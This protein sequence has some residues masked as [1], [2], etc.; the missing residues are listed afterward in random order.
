KLKEY[1]NKEGLSDILNELENI[2]EEKYSK[3]HLLKELSQKLNLSEKEKVTL[4][5]SIDIE[6]IENNTSK[7]TEIKSKKEKILERIENL[8]A[9][10]SDNDE[11]KDLKSSLKK[12]TFEKE[13][14]DITKH[15]LKSSMSLIEKQIKI[16][17]ENY[18]EFK[19]PNEIKEQLTKEEQNILKEM[20]TSQIQSAKTVLESLSGNIKK[21]LNSHVILEELNSNKFKGNLDGE[22]S[23]KPKEDSE[24]IKN[25]ASF[26]NN[27]S[28]KS[29][30][31]AN[32]TISKVK[33]IIDPH[34]V[35]D[36]IN[37]KIKMNFNKNTNKMKITLSPAS[38]GEVEIEIKLKDGQLKAEFMVEDEKIKKI[39]E[40][41][42][43]N[44]KNE[45]NKKGVEVSE[46]KVGI[47]NQQQKREKPKSN[48]MKFIEKQ[49]I[50]EDDFNNAENN[51]S[52]RALEDPGINGLN[53]LA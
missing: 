2:P 42:L 22:N 33:T 41:N 49:K 50:T 21:S 1:I 10:N 36:Q 44:L 39:V 38:L 30:T 4:R 35:M 31:K 7:K 46:L 37:D 16:L 53:I 15:D 27:L 17:E 26:L 6:K 9:D 5:K 3:D 14:N 43:S 24:N 32:Q 28:T 8:L 18:A 25:D 45:L 13:K 23:K 19:L 20:K 12:R 40:S 34:E 11:L 51:T 52:V 47:F 29:S 48:I